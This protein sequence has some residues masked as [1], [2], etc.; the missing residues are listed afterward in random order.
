MQLVLLPFR[1]LTETLS[2]AGSSAAADSE[3]WRV[4]Q[5]LRKTMAKVWISGIRQCVLG[6]IDVDYDG[7]RRFHAVLQPEHRKEMEQAILRTKYM[8]VL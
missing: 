1:A 2:Q 3:V 8:Q 6:E 4:Q 5:E 7:V